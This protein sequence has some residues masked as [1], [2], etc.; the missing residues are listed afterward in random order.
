MIER[1]GG[2]PF[3][4]GIFPD[5]EEAIASIADHARSADLV[6]TIGGA[7]VGEHDLVQKALGPRGFELDFWKIAM[8]PGKPLIFGRLGATPLLGLPGNPVSSLVC[9]ILF[10][11]PA[12]AALLGA[13]STV[14]CVTGRLLTDINTNDSRQDYL[15]ARLDR[16]NEEYFIEPFTV[17]DSSMLS[18]FVRA[19]ALI[20]RPPHAPAAKAGD[21]VPIMLLD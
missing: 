12:V 8:R 16:R 15:R 1:W 17:Q 5:T 9:A 10:L 11:E 6:V 13:P 2:V 18:L 19:E 14:R 21:R 20:V 3:D 4:L 7:S